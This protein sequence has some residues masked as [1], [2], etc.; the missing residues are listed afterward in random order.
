VAVI[1]VESNTANGLSSKLTEEEKYNSKS[2]TT[3]YGNQI[4]ELENHLKSLCI[5]YLVTDAYYSKHEFAKVVRGSG[6]HQIGKLRHDAYLSWPY[7]GE[8]LGRG[9]PRKYD[10]VAITK[11]KLIRWKYVT[12][13]EDGTSMYEGIVWSRALKALVKVV[14]LRR[15]EEEKTVQQALLFSTDVNL[16][17]STVFEYYKL[18]FQIEF[19]FLDC[20][21]IVT[22][23][24][25]TSF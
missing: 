11:G 7:E 8:F 13:L 24:A 10:G 25:Q 6:L 3:Q 2:R 17:A 1:D 20:Y 22:T 12:T 14:I 16:P 19:L 5:N 23:G 18:R 4:K 15:K 9:R 21:V